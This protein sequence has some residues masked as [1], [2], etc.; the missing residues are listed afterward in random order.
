MKT[1]L[2]LQIQSDMSTAPPPPNGPFFRGVQLSLF[3]TQTC[4]LHKNVIFLKMRNF[5]GGF[6]NPPETLATFLLSCGVHVSVVLSEA[7]LTFTLGLC[8]CPHATE[9]RAIAPDIASH[10]RCVQCQTW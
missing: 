2:Y 3:I 4:L 9:L 5:S 6:L 10:Q 8:H 7:D 1:Y